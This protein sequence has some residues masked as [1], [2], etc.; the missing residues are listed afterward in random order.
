M[1]SST[2]SRSTS[3]R[4]PAR[5]TWPASSYIRAAF[6]AAS[7]RSASAKTISGPLPP[8]SPVNGTRFEAAARPIARAVS[9]EPVNEIRLTSGCEVS[10]APA[11]SP[12]PWTTLKT[13]GRHPRL[14]GQVGEQRARERR[15]LGRLQDHGAAGGERRG[16][17][18]GREHEGRVPGRDH[19]GG[20]GRHPDHAVERSRSSSRPAPRRRRRARRR[21]GSCGRR[22]R[23]PARA[24]TR[25]ASPCPRTRPRRSGRR[26]RRSARRAGRGRGG[27][28][29]GRA[30]AQAPKADSR[31]RDR[32][33]GLGLAA[34][35]RPGRGRGRRS[36]SGRRSARPRRPARRR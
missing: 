24:A 15:P 28:P 23:S 21:R 29:P 18:P 17:L 22:A 25:A 20:A 31:G 8:S 4:V 10:A 32:R 3:S 16:R 36:G 33:R 5:Q 14:G 35:R 6:A 27:G 2:T 12:I 30:P 19:D 1:N 7:S 26:W 11:R 13:P 34:R 9:G